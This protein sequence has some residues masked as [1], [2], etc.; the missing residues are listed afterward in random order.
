MLRMKTVLLGNGPELV[1]GNLDVLDCRPGLADH[2]GDSVVEDELGEHLH[3]DVHVQVSH[4]SVEPG[5][6][7]G[8]RQYQTYL[9]QISHLCVGPDSWRSGPGPS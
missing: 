2:T 6:K 4:G 8:I 9:I 3:V 1:V 7:P 5:R